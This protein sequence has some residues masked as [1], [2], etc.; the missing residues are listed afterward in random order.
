MSTITTKPPD[1]HRMNTIP[2]YNDP[3]W[4]QSWNGVVKLM[5]IKEQ[6]E[7][8]R[9]QLIQSAVNHGLDSPETLRISMLLDQLVIKY[10]R[11]IAKHGKKY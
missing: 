5:V 11:I 1:V 3:R 2:I 8:Y 7:R 6:I 10:Q 4:C 9:K